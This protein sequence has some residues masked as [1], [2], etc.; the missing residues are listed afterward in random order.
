M[1]SA[2]AAYGRLAGFI[3][4][5][6]GT[7]DWLAVTQ[8]QVDAFADVT[9]DRQFIHVDP[10][11][12][13]RESPYGATVAHGFLTL[14]LLTHLLSSIDAPDAADT[15][16]T[17]GINYGFDRVRFISPVPVGSRIRASSVISQVELPIASSVQLTRMVTVEIEGQPKPA[18]S[19]EWITRRV[20]A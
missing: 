10:E 8:S 20:Y 15:D 17:V 7:G 13:A 9:E 1:T 4:K 6:E 5:P 3:G 19:A 14:S 16:T 18:L 12:A 2:E 11:R